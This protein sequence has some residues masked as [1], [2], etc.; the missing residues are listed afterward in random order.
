[1]N[2]FQILC[3]YKIQQLKNKV[4]EF[5]PIR[6]T[7]LPNDKLGGMEAIITGWHGDQLQKASVN[8]LG[9]KDCEI[10]TR[11]LDNQTGRIDPG[12]VCS[13]GVPQVL[14]GKVKII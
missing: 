5:E 4:H 12:V 6:L 13:I 8:I 9:N 10:T 1:M 11:A 7:T 2:D 14:L 3:C